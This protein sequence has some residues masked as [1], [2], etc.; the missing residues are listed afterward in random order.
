M[1]TPGKYNA[2]VIS[3]G[4]IATEKNTKT[5]IRM[6]LT[7]PL[8]AGQTID[9]QRRADL[10]GQREKIDAAMKL[11][12]WSGRG[13]YSV[14][15][16]TAVVAVFVARICSDGIERVECRYLNA[17]PRDMACSARRA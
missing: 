14:R 15:P 5:V 16:G 2:K 3:C 12:G 6:V 17:A 13:S 8:R 7:D 9:W 11:C 4:E 1:I 10:P